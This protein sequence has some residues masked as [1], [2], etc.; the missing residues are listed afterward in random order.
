MKAQ[1]ACANDLQLLAKAQAAI[2]QE[3]YSDG[4]EIASRVSMTSKH[5]AEAAILVSIAIEHRDGR[6][7]AIRVLREAP[8][9][10][11]TPGD[12]RVWNR[13]AE[14]ELSGGMIDSAMRSSIRAY[15]CDDNNTIA[16]RRLAQLNGHA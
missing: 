11:G 5:F 12:V 13:M 4:I 14:L 3:R 9:A 1:N 15:E 7:E 16:L 8:V 10:S 6:R 2:N